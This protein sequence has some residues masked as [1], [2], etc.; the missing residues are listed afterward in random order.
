MCNNSALKRPSTWGQKATLPIHALQANRSIGH[1]T[2][3]G[4]WLLFQCN[5]FSFSLFQGAVWVACIHARAAGPHEWDFGLAGWQL[6]CGTLRFPGCWDCVTAIE[7]WA[8]CAILFHIESRAFCAILFHIKRYLVPHWKVSFLCRLVPQWKVSFLCRLVPHW[9]VSFLCC[10]VPHWKVGFL[11][12]LVPHWKVGF[13]C[14]LVPHWKVGFLCHLVPHW[15]VSFLCRLVPHWKVSFLCHLVP[16]WKVSFLC[17]LVPQVTL[18]PLLVLPMSSLFFCFCFIFWLWYYVNL[19]RGQHY[20]LLLTALCWFLSGCWRFQYSTE[21][22][23]LGRTLFSYINV[24]IY[25]Y[26]ISVWTVPVLFYCVMWWFRFFSNSV[27]YSWF[28]FRPT[29]LVSL[30]PPSMECSN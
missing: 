6:F 5:C 1:K 9:K 8:L 4:W 26:I 29:V 12:R 3:S 18:L 30:F 17:R 20:F 21:Y 15:K 11:C 22:M 24:Y 2:K 7:G 19:N 16:H 27:L 23:Q 13:L 28:L 25:I 10:L 14:R